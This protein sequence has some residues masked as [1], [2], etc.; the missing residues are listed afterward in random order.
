M[1]KVVSFVGSAINFF[2]VLILCQV[3]LACAVWTKF[4]LVRTFGKGYGSNGTTPF[5]KISGIHSGGPIT[6]PMA[7]FGF[8]IANI[9]DIDGNGFDDLGKF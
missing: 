7:R 2:L 1:K 8:S 3:N 4:D 9:G 5:T 6:Q